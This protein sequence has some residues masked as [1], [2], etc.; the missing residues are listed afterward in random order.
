MSLSLFGTKEIRKGKEGW[1][2]FSPCYNVCLYSTE[3]DPL[4]YISLSGTDGIRPF[5]FLRVIMSVYI[6]LRGEA[7]LF[8]LAALK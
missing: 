1:A 7:A 5:Y 6:L 8:S 4:Y 3:G 2:L